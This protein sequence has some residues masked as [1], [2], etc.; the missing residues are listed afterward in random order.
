M[1]FGICWMV[2]HMV[3]YNFWKSIRQIL[4]NY[5]KG[6]ICTIETCL[7]Y[8]KIEKLQIQYFLDINCSWFDSITLRSVY[9][10]YEMWSESNS[11]YIQRLEL[12][13]ANIL[14]QL[15]EERCSQDSRDSSFGKELPKNK[16]RDETSNFT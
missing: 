12:D 15:L 3:F 6:N 2:F 1:K 11:V 8:S 5:W 16:L 10:L 9:R 4:S 14:K 7:V 13:R